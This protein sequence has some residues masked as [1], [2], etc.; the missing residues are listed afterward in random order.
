MRTLKVST[1]KLEE[2]KKRLA[3]DYNYITC[4]A[5]QT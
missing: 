2:G 3:D 1:L 4:H 5:P